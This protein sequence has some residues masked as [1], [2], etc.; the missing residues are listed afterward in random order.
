MGQNFSIGVGAKICVTI[1]DQLFFERL[2][3]FDDAVVNERDLAGGVEMRMGILVVDLSVRRPAS[4]ADS[5]R[6]SGRFLRNK[7]GE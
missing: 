6:S 4:V 1:L 3:I 7:F 5:L 2:I